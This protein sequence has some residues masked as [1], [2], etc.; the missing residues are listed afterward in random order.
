[1][2]VDSERES[3]EWK[4]ESKEERVDVRK[5]KEVGGGRRKGRE[6]GRRWRKRKRRTRWE[7]IFDIFKR[8]SSFWRHFYCVTWIMLFLLIIRMEYSVRSEAFDEETDDYFPATLPA[9]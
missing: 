5:V 8:V 6:E 1:M 7:V 3:R 2:S 9:F 4:E